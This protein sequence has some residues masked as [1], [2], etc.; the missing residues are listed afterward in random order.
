[1]SCEFEGPSVAILSGECVGDSS[2]L[3]F[4]PRKK[5]KC[6]KL[7]SDYSWLL[8]FQGMTCSVAE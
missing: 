5:S 1:M 3:R 4:C 2:K 7:I 8:D 6:C